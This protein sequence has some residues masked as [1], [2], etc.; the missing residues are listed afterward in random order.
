MS[1]ENY[2]YFYWSK[3]RW[4]HRSVDGV[5]IK[6]FLNYKYHFVIQSL[7]KSNMMSLSLFVYVFVYKNLANRWIDINPLYN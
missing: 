6:M 2:V 1:M 4:D 3:R 7:Y 5:R